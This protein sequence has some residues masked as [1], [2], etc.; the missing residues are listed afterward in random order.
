MEAS[1]SLGA[2]FLV[3]VVVKDQLCKGIL[4]SNIQTEML[5]QEEGGAKCKRIWG[6]E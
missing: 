2:M 1:P 6:M 3:V 5:L 4:G